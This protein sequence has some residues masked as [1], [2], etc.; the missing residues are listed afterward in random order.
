MTGISQS[1]RRSVAV[2]VAAGAIAL[3]AADAS[4]QGRGGA[5]GGG[6]GPRGGGGGPRGGGAVVV[7]PRVYAPIYGGFYGGY[8]GSPFLYYGFGPMDPFWGSYWSPYY[9]Y[10]RWNYGF[11]GTYDPNTASAR[12]QVTPKQAEVYVDGYLTGSV[13]DFDGA[14]QRLN[15]P[16][17]EHELTFYLDGYRTLTQKVLFRPHSTLK[18][19]YDLAKLAAGEATGPRPVPSAE[20]DRDDEVDGPPMPRRG[21]DVEPRRMP[22]PRPE[23]ADRGDRERDG[24]GTLAIRV[25]PEG[26]RILVDGQEWNASDST[27]PLRLELQAGSH[28]IDVQANGFAPFHRTVR[29]RP[30]DTT[31]LNVSLSR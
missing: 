17:G 20:P 1:V 29:V 16:P 13:D 30:G 28:E 18:I 6:G 4:A 7:S 24:Y 15:V 14:L 5:R 3:V 10:G 8:Y 26:A 2:V 11:G 23:R 19:K 31:S 21:G 22:P 27:G 9:G 12:L 25:Q